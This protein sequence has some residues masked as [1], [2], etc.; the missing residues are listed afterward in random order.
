MESEFEKYMSYATALES[1]LKN[2]EIEISNDN[3]IDLVKAVMESD[4]LIGG[5]DY[6]LPNQF[7]II[8]AAKYIANKVIYDKEIKNKLLGHEHR[9]LV[10]VESIEE[11][12]RLNLPKKC[13]TKIIYVK[14]NGNKSFVINI[15]SRLNSMML[16]PALKKKVYP[17]GQIFVAKLYD[18]VRMYNEMGDSLF[19]KNVRFSLE[20]DKNDVETSIHSTLENEPDY[21]WFYNNGITLLAD[22]VN[23]SDSKSIEIFAVDGNKFSV[24]NGAQTITACADFYY[25]PFIDEEKIEKAK[26]AYVM[27]RIISVYE[28]KDAQDLDCEEE[29]IKEGA[30]RKGAKER[31]ES[32][33]SVSLNRQKPIDEEDLAIN[34]E[35]VYMINNIE[36]DEHIKINIGRK[37]E[38]QKKNTYYLIDVARFVMATKLQKPG[39]AKN[40]YRGYIL[41]MDGDRFKKKEI[42]PKFRNIEML[43]QEYLN[44]YGLV[45]LANILYQHYEKWQGELEEYDDTDKKNYIQYMLENGGYYFVSVVTRAIFASEDGQIEN[46]NID[47]VKSVM[48]KLNDNLLNDIF[49][50]YKKL[51]V[52]IV[53]LGKKIDYNE[54]KKD[55]LYKEM[56]SSQSYA[57]FKNNI[58]K[59]IF[60]PAEI[61]EHDV[62]NRRGKKEAS[63]SEI[64]ETSGHDDQKFPETE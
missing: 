2:E 5:P 37:G 58:I 4:S 49:E 60:S 39:A 32:K 3:L 13:I 11:K 57:V 10:I 28:D 30:S 29:L 46:I 63:K 27:L 51:T 62:L 14:N 48:D 9:L 64:V 17:K 45:N 38:E 8:T 1:S 43:E 55:S 54:M 24:I 22:K 20:S 19:E 12:L 21:F 23:Y 56:F 53:N 18:I 34:S 6:M 33:I 25:S 41:K 59:M 40:T 16:E 50:E 36:V 44:Q 7:Y 26:S 42:L 35:T 61:F 31:L 47:I 52:S 15:D